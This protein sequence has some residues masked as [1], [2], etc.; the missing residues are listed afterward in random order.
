MS[1][2]KKDVYIREDAEH[3]LNRLSTEIRRGN[4]FNYADDKTLDLFKQIKKLVKDFG[5]SYEQTAKALIMVDES[6]YKNLVKTEDPFQKEG[7]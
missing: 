7:Q 4:F 2:S 6:F 5:A 3:H 1:E